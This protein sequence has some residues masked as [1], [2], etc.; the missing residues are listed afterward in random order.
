MS[1]LFSHDVEVGPHFVRVAVERGI[2]ASMG[3]RGG[4]HG[5]GADGAL[6]YAAGEVVEVGERVEVPLGRSNQTAAGI[7]VQAG[8]KELLD[9]LD[10]GRVKSIVRRTGARLPA[11]LVE[12]AVWMAGYYVCPIG[13]VLATMLPAAVKHATGLKRR[14]VVEVTGASPPEDTRLT[15]AVRRTWEAIQAAAPE[16]GALGPMP[17]REFAAR[18]GAATVGPINRLIAMGV[19]RSIE[20]TEVAAAA[21]MWEGRTIEQQARPRPTLTPSQQHVVN[22]IR[23][24]A[25]RF[26]VH[27]IRGVTGSGKTEVYLRVIEEA[28]RDRADGAPTGAAIVLVPEI[29]LTPQTA[30]RFI[31]RFGGEGGLGVAV[32]HSGLSAS[33]RHKQW[34]M[35]ASGEARVVV[36]ARS[37]VYSPMPR[38]GVI[39]V[40][41]EHDS[42]YKQDQLP[43]YNARDVAIKRGQIEGCPVVLGTA[44]PSLESW[45]NTLPPAKYSLWELTERVGGGRLPPVEVVDVVEERRLAGVEA[46]SGGRGGGWRLIGPTLGLALRKTLEQG[47]QAILLLNRRGFANYICCPSAACGWVMK[48]DSCDASMIFHK[49][50]AGAEKGYLRCHHCLAEQRLPRDCPVCGRRVI[51]LGAGTQRLEEELGRDFGLAA[52]TDYLRVDGDTMRTAADYFE[53]L[54]SFA[55]GRVNLL[56]GTQMI[57]KGLDFPNV[58]LVGVVDAD[59]AL[60]L[61]DFRA[62][63]RTFQLVSQVAGRAGRGDAPGR[64]VVQTASP[65]VPAI[66]HAA[67]HDYASF[68][69]DEL[70]VRARAGLPPITRM[71]RVVCRHLNHAKALEAAGIIAGALREEAGRIGPDSGVRIEGPADCPISRVAD[72]YRIAIEVIAPARGVIQAL[73]GAV[74]AR[75]LLTSDAATAVDVD[76]IAVL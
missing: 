14:V 60:A 4:G 59:T 20:R 63:E 10:P 52:G 21:G 48:C 8:G 33:Q 75:G 58:R 17:A 24:S 27:L 56:L 43:R 51:I 65:H 11:T 23:E 7:V 67:R 5:R 26:S 35:V 41:E 72:H 66:V 69:A 32:L 62:A 73:L 74:R 3:R 36:G 13:M 25:G 15:P 18:V 46:W 53:A 42:S 55:A 68:A 38:A 19:L 22:G 29:S 2:E 16:L 61:P 47:G 44:T 64:V 28:L 57:A 31:D 12:L 71:A 49:H 6:T 37:A 40:D 34:A 30:G 76:P 54:S 1:S 45:V 39:I 9:G 70:E 50:Q